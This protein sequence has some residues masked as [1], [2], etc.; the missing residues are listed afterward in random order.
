MAFCNKCGKPIADGAKFCSHCGSV[1]DSVEQNTAVVEENVTK[2]VKNKPALDDMAIAGGSDIAGKSS[3]KTILALIAGVL[4][5]AAIVFALL[6]RSGNQPYKASDTPS[7]KEDTTKENDLFAEGNTITISDIV[8]S[9]DPVIVYIK[10]EEDTAAI[11]DKNEI[12][13]ALVFKKGKVKSYRANIDQFLTYG[14]LSKMSDKEI[15]EALDTNSEKARNT[16]FDSFQKEIETEKSEIED[17]VSSYEWVG[18]WTENG[19]LNLITSEEKNNLL[20]SYSRIMNGLSKVDKN[21][22]IKL[23]WSSCKIMIGTDSSGNVT[24][25]ELIYFAPSDRSPY[26][27]NE[28]EFWIDK[29]NTDGMYYQIIY[30][31]DAQRAD[32]ADYGEGERAAYEKVEKRDCNYLEEGNGQKDIDDFNVEYGLI[33]SSGQGQAYS[34]YDSNYVALGNLGFVR[35]NNHFILNF[36]EPG[37]EIPDMSGMSDEDLEDIMQDALTEAFN[38]E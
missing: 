8:N 34:I 4:V 27:Y 33:N 37:K 3:K 25:K 19:Y 35:T 1:V 36:D 22:C 11:P 29:K 30:T 21:K 28:G 12:P 31:N 20:D 15:L 14:E 23:R 13:G 26:S 7:K 17:I 24:D 32:P 6:N 16:A 38:K 10:G 2:S 18:F 5:V 9:K